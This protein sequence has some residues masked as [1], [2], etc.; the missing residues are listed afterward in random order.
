MDDAD[1]AL[2]RHRDRQPRLGDGVHRRA[3]QRH[4]DADVA[5]EPA[6]RRRPA[7]GSTVE[8]RGTSSTSSKVSAV[9]R[10]IEIWSVLRT[11]VRV[12]I[13]SSQC[14][15]SAYV[16]AALAPA[17]ALAPWHFLYF[18]PL[19]HGHGSLRPTFGSSRL[20]VLIDVVAAGARRARRLGAGARAG[21]A[22]PPMRAERRRRRRRRARS[23]SSAAAGAARRWRTGARRLGA[24][25]ARRPASAATG[26]GRSL[27]RSRPSSP[28]TAR[29]SPSCTRRADRAG[30]SRAGRCLPS[31][32][33]GCRGDPSTARRR[34][35]A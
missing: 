2:L 17:C 22:L 15:T 10:P 24:V 25:V 26:S 9:A 14:S 12:S 4:V 31:G 29:S 18:L 13:Q 33:R 1:A 16:V 27:P 34:S 3:E 11:S 5:R 21:A 30:R 28:G 23:A 6:T 8:C 20:T 7:L 35:A 32:G 19:P